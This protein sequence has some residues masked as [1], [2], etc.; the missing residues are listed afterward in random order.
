MS[1]ERR[2]QRLF[3]FGSNGSGQLGIGH[4]DDVSAPQQCVYGSSL[5][6][7]VVKQLAAGGNH[8]MILHANGDIASTG[9]NSDGRCWY[10]EPEASDRWSTNENVASAEAATPAT[11][12][13]AATWAASIAA[14][15]SNSRAIM[16]CG[17]GNSGELGLGRNIITAQT[18]QRINSSWPETATITKLASCMGHVVAVLS[19]GEV[20]GWGKGRKGQLGQPTENV[21]TPR[22]I[23]GIPFFAVEAVCGKD[24]TCIFGDPATGELLVLGSIGSDRFGIGSNTPTSV[25]GWKQVAAS[26]G[27]I[28]VLFPSGEVV[29]WGRND[30]GQLAPPNLPS[31]ERIAS[32]S[33]HCLGLTKTGK[34]LAWGWGEHGNCGTSTDESGDVKGRWNEIPLPHPV[35]SIFA[36]CATSFIVTEVDGG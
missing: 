3:A 11:E 9:D 2:G 34:V 8:A 10:E 16:S 18:P 28:Y 27:S 21:W 35:T 12:H 23:E 14:C 36:G 26:W 7:T 32:G 24:F 17:A 29:S 15:R 30:H 1:N 6:F 31:L 25:A 13:L 33:E 5:G 22:K 20:W 4:K 19:N